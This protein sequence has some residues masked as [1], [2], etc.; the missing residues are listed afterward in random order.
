VLTELPAPLVAIEGYRSAGLT[1]IH[2]R[3]LEVAGALAADPAPRL[4]VS[5]AL[6]A[7][8]NFDFAR[9][10]EYGE[11]LR[12]AGERDADPMTIAESEYILGIVTFW[13]GEL[14]QAKT[15]FERAIQ[16]VRPEHRRDHV[17][18][19][20]QDPE[21]TCGMRLACTLC[22]LGET[23][24]AVRA[25]DAA[26]AVALEIDHPYNLEVT[27]IFAALLAFEM[28][29]PFAL[30]EHVAQLR[31]TDSEHRPAQVRAVLE[32]FD[33]Y[34]D[35]LDRRVEGIVRIQRVLNDPAMSE[36]AFCSTRA[37]WPARGAAGS[38]QRIAL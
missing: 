23:A 37:R 7:L 18:K 13:L 4:L 15:H 33:G 9:A 25:R 34:L 22:I 12:D 31:A 35:V 3:A 21:S 6:A 38:T 20:G 30:R 32:A 14:N 16:S 8:S 11:R 28:R 19:F 2:D 17:L 5:L 10:R 1:A 29:E 26:L 24:G 27:R 36:R